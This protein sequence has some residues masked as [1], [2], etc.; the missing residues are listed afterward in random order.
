MSRSAAM[1]PHASRPAGHHPVAR[2]IGWFSW[3]AAVAVIVVTLIMFG[4]CLILWLFRDELAARV[5]I[6][7]QQRLPGWRVQIRSLERVEGYGIVLRGLVVSDPLQRGAAARVLEVDEIRVRCATNL[8]SLLAGHT[9]PSQLVLRRPRLTAPCAAALLAKL[10]QPAPMAWNWDNLPEVRIVDGV[11]VL[12]D[13]Q[14]G[15]VALREIQG[16]LH[17]SQE[18]QSGRTQWNLLLRGRGPQL[19]AVQ[20]QVAYRPDDQTWEV[21]S[22]IRQAT[23]SESWVRWLVSRLTRTAT[24][25]SGSGSISCDI[26]AGRAAQA[27]RPWVKID[28][29]IH[30]AVVHAPG[31][32]LTLTGVSGSFFADSNQWKLSSCAGWCGKS[33]VQLDVVQHGW[34]AE[35]PA[36]VSLAARQFRLTRPMISLLPAAMQEDWRKSQ[37]LGLLD[38]QLQA[39]RGDGTW[40]TTAIVRCRDV[41]ARH[42]ELPYTFRGLHGV[43]KL[44]NH[45]LD[46]D[47]QAIVDGQVVKIASQLNRAGDEVVGWTELHCDEWVTLDK[48]LTSVLPEA[49]QDVVAALQAAGKVSGHARIEALTGNQTRKHIEVNVQGASARYIHFPYPI[50]DIH[51]RLVIDDARCVI[52]RLVGRKGSAAITCTGLWDGDATTEPKL[53][54][55]FDCR[56]VPLDDQLHQALDAQGQAMW[57]EVRPAGVL[58]RLVVNVA[59]D[60]DR[61]TTQWELAGSQDPCA[62][63]MDGR[64]MSMFLK[65]FPYALQNISGRFIYRNGVLQFDEVRARHDNTSLQ[66]HGKVFSDQE[67]RRLVFDRLVVEGLRADR[68]LLAAAPSGLRQVAE[69]LHPS[70]QMT[71]DG[72]LDLLLDSDPRRTRSSWDVQLDL[73]NAAV[74]CGAPLRSI[75]GSI[76]LAGSADARGFRNRGQLNIDSLMLQGAQITGIRGPFWNDPRQSVLGSP[77]GPTRSDSPL[78]VQAKTLGGDVALRG[79]VLNAPESPFVL[80]ARMSDV[81]LQQAAAMFSPANRQVSGLLSGEVFLQGNSHGR[82]T[83]VGGGEAH[84][85]QADLYET[86]FMMKLLTLLA[87]RPPESNAFSSADA[88]LRIEGDQLYLDKIQLSGESL[89]LRGSGEVNTNKDVRA[90]LYAAVRGEADNRLAGRV[91]RAAS[92]QL[93]QIDVDGKTDDPKV[94]R[95][96]L[97]ELND[98]IKRLFPELA[99]KENDNDQGPLQRLNEAVN[100]L[101]GWRR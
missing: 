101:A 29:R 85:R 68:D 67:G 42:H 83:W 37:P 34:T 47:L 95:R 40:N 87:I 58:D 25:W 93:L 24:P 76:H 92:R 49:Q 66:A 41:S 64:T 80:Y 78:E 70:G 32:A 55:A 19:G 36:K 72:R 52:E 77:P 94:S 1:A 31:D 21:R 86:P 27:A 56:E 38:L 75:R 20:T 71:L 100:P 59:H 43:A 23:A 16:A 74:N 12:G 7:L 62:A 28:G 13:P 4:D 60:P 45:T 89:T 17:P 57:A 53:R 33:L 63:H 18:K 5:A 82:H 22:K 11:A 97:P 14:L 90:N 79:V 81:Q 10:R 6:E 2:C 30:D 61:Q 69:H 73:E 48:E 96:P 9:H 39:E 54:L 44:S 99:N 50:D 15:D 8:E 84:L 98:A 88:N 91:F 51:G 65:Q 35:A 3:R 46:L 26:S